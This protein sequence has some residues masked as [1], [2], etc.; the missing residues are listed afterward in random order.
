MNRIFL[1]IFLI[2]S[3]L[4]FGIFAAFPRLQAFSAVQKELGAKKAELESRESYFAHV[5][6]L[7]DRIN[8]EVL[9]AKID[10]A[11]PNDPQ[12]P[13]LHDFLQ[14]AAAQSGLS[15][16]SIAVS[17]GSSAQGA[18]LGRI[19]SSLQLGGS[20][21]G[22]KVFLSNLLRASRMTDINSISFSS[23]SAGT[24]FVFNIRLTSYS[25]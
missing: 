15:L 1:S 10:A 7:Q 3:S 5:K 17:Q 21:D 8:G 24:G 20:Y 6:D 22:L 4:I 16:R 9:V 13:A 18:R 25:Y 23:P 12:L 19:V 2:G 11:I 14:S